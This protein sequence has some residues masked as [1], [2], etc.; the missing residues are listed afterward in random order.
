MPSAFGVQSYCFRKTKDNA[1]T[2][3]LVKECGL[4][5]IEICKVQID[6][7]DS[8]AHKP[9]ID[10]Y[11]SAG[12]NIA[13]IGVNAISGDETSARSLFEFAKAAG[14]QAMTVDFKIDSVP[15]CFSLADRLAE[16]YGVALGIHNHGGRHWLGSAQALEWVFAQT[17]SRIGFTLDTAW[18]LDSGE[19]PVELVRRF[20]ERLRIIHI[21]DFL[22]DEARSP[23]DV[24]VGSGNLDLPALDQALSDVGFTG[25]AILEYEG[26]VD[27]PV[28]ALKKCIEAVNASMPKTISR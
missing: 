4:D 11:R 5:T 23:R 16:E 27:D 17:S 20:G 7:E 22:F 15:E 2:A 19:D 21:K 26:D 18:A 25:P 12:V 24:I 6:F 3:K 9:A 10:A 14:L 8:S 1:G 13:S 28:P